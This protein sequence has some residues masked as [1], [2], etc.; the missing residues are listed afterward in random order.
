MRRECTLLKRPARRVL[1][2]PQPLTLSSLFFCTCHETRNIF[3]KDSLTLDCPLHF[4]PSRRH[5]I[6]LLA[7]ATNQKKFLFT[8]SHATPAAERC[9]RC[10]PASRLP[11]GQVACLTRCCDKGRR[12][13]PC[14][15]RTVKKQGV[16]SSPPCLP[17]P[18][19]DCCHNLDSLYSSPYNV[20]G[21]CHF[22]TDCHFR[23][24]A[25]RENNQQARPRHMLRIHSFHP[26]SPSARLV[27]EV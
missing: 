15:N 26:A 22:A 6:M 13:L 16:G 27:L 20:A 4:G 25:N 21:V 17:T 14:D 12:T 11:P 9:W 10:Q 23:Y 3:Q 19:R 8:A 7:L 18:P 5:C 24:K 1:W 2:K